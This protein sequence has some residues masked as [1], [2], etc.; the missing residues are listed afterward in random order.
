M[1]EPLVGGVMSRIREGGKSDLAGRRGRGGILKWENG[2]V[3]LHGAV[4][5]DHEGFDTGIQGDRRSRDNAKTPTHRKSKIF[6]TS[7]VLFSTQQLYRQQCL[8]LSELSI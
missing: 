2:L 5:T 1:G 4:C 7:G 3:G 8:L 6:S